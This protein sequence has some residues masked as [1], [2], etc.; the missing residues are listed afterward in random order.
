MLIKQRGGQI[1]QKKT[2]SW[3]S[4]KKGVRKRNRGLKS[5]EGFKKGKGVVKNAPNV[6][7]LT[8]I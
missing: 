4:K 5:T 1:N 6:Y 3:G 8:A 2:N 7:K